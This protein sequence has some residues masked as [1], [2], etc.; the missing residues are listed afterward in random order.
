MDMMEI[1]NNPG[2]VDDLVHIL[3]TLRSMMVGKKRMVMTVVR[4][5]SF[6]YG[7]LIDDI[8]DEDV[9]DEHVVHGLLTDD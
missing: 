3:V 1:M 9:G 5:N 8:V 6:P 7:C 4:C 2:N